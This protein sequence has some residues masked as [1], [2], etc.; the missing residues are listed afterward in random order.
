MKYLLYSDV[1]FCENSS[2]IQSRGQ[3]YS[4]RLEYLIRSI[5]WAEEQAIINN[6]DVVICLGDFFDRS[7]IKSEE[8]TALQEINWVNLPHYFIVGN[9]EASNKSLTF[10]SVEVL[11]KINNFNII[12]EPTSLNNEILLLPYIKES[13]LKS[14][15]EPRSFR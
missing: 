12:S 3:K 13:E 11:R 9:H 2:S 14:L 4:T 8:A 10:N 6:C 7:D 1:H 5:N 15:K